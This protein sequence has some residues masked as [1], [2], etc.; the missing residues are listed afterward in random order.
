[1]LNLNDIKF[2]FNIIIISYY[3]NKNNK[4]NLKPLKFHFLLNYFSFYSSK[5]NLYL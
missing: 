5:K 4:I 2:I 3:Y 1:M